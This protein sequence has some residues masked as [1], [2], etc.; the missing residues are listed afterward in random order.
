MAT[1]NQRVPVFAKAPTLDQ[2]QAAYQAAAVKKP[3][4]AGSGS[5]AGANSYAALYAQAVKIANAQAQ[6]QLKDIAAAQ[7]QSLAA[8]NRAADL[9]DA[10]GL[11]YSRGLTQLGLDKGI[12]TLYDNSAN[13]QAS[14]A[15]GFRGSIQD[16]ATADAERMRQMLAGT[17]QEGAVRDQGENMGNVAYALGGYYPGTALQGQGTNLAA[18]AALQPGFAQQFGQM[19]AATARQDWRDET[20]P[21]F[22]S[23]R[24]K[25]IAGKPALIQAALK[26]QTD[27]ANQQFDNYVNYLNATRALG[28]KTAAVKTYV[29]KDGT[30]YAI[31]PTTGQYIPTGGVTVPVKPP[32]AGGTAHQKAI[33]RRTKAVND[34]TDLMNTWLNNGK[35][36]TKKVLVVNPRTLTK[37]YIDQ[38]NPVGYQE[39]LTYVKNQLWLK[40]GKKYGYSRADLAEIA[41]TILNAN[42][43]KQWAAPPLIAGA[44]SQ[45]NPDANTVDNPVIP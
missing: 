40:L 5:G 43:Y 6:Q 1:L 25:V 19:A 15:A 10:K 31:D 23:E 33:Q 38:P 8:A 12:Q 28:G 3:A 41:K 37:S 42:G 34:V 22:T 24:Q 4:K 17:G 35:S 21:T 11:A 29:G 27:L 13:T 36:R 9:E 18:L 16:E 20:L 7:A 14:L 26:A 2:A 45:G 39:A 30:T 32:P 44:V